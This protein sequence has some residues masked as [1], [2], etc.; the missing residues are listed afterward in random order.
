MVKI[1]RSYIVMLIIV[2]AA[3]LLFGVALKS[4][5]W[6]KQTKPVVFV[7]NSTGIPLGFVVAPS[8]QIVTWERQNDYLSFFC[9]YNNHPSDF[10]FILIDGMWDKGPSFETIRELIEECKNVSDL[11]L[12]MPEEETPEPGLGDDNE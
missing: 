11:E 2:L 10:K 7:D 9:W 12:P 6:F 8:I 4:P 5:E 3:L 1:N